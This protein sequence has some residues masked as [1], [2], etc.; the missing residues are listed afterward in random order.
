LEL[1]KLS[2]RA[3]QPDAAVPYLE[4][5]LN[6]GPPHE[7]SYIVYGKHLYQ[8]KQMLE[9]I[10]KLEKALSINPM[11]AEAHYNLGI[12][13][14]ELGKYE[15]ANAHAHKAYKLGY[16]LLDLKEKLKERGMWRPMD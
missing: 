14:L 16:Q 1:S 3:G 10:L 2:H 15:D 7:V 8:S 11:S 13:Y 4:Y 9:A 6:F 5:A 12:A